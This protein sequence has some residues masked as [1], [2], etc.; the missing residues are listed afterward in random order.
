MCGSVSS[1]LFRNMEFE[2]Q[3]LNQKVKRTLVEEAD[4]EFYVTNVHQSAPKLLWAAYDLLDLSN[5]TSK[6]TQWCFLGD[7]VNR[8]GLSKCIN[9]YVYSYL[10]KESDTNLNL[11]SNCLSSR[12]LLTRIQSR[13][14]IN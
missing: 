8:K 9:K 6:L 14:E 12:S 1:L 4:L 3:R 10:V 13:Q 7:Y 11:Q 2:T 5:S